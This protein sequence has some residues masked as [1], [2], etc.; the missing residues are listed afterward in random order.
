MNT[1][2]NAYI[3]IY[4]YTAFLVQ[5]YHVSVPAI[6]CHI[7]V[8]GYKQFWFQE[9]YILCS[10]LWWLLTVQID[11]C[12]YNVLFGLDALL[13]FW[14]GLGAPWNFSFIKAKLALP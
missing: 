11:K 9:F 2:H 12:F 7:F 6:T 14:S 1:L 4:K 10:I 8:L 3:D 5:S 13:P